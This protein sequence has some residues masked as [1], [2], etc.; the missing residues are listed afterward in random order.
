MILDG[1]EPQLQVAEEEESYAKT[2]IDPFSRS[3]YTRVLVI[4]WDNQT[5]ELSV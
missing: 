5:D 2:T 1:L 4:S 3:S